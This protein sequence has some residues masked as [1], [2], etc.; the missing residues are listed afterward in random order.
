M[1]KFPLVVRKGSDGVRRLFLFWDRYDHT[2]MEAHMEDAL[3]EV[4][5]VCLGKISFHDI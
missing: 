1:G 3:T 2:S 4:C 5:L